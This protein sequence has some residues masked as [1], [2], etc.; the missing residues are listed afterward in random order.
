MMDEINKKPTRFPGPAYRIESERFVIR[1]WDPK[2][3]PLLKAAVDESLDHLRPWMPWTINEPEILQ[4]K[5]DRLR[6]FR[7]KFDLGRDYMYGIFDPI[8]KQV[9][10]GTGLHTSVEGN[11]REIGYWIHVMHINRGL[12][13]EATGALIRV[14]FEI[15]KVDRVEIHCG[16]KNIR[17][18]TIPKKLGFQYEATLKRRYVTADGGPRDTMI[19]SLF[20]PD[21]P[22]SPASLIPIKAFDAAG[23]Q[24][25]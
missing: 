5:I 22:D 6:K 19:W 20:A 8:E 11:A 7:A 17:S 9:I 23:R 4:T 16:P 24:I 25:L 14:A 21:Y 10:G 18:V 15:D 13:S 12:A 3:A 1:C 2:D